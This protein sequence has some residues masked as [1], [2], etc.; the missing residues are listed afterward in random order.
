MTRCVNDYFSLPVLLLQGEADRIVS[1]IEAAR[2][3]QKLFVG[4]KQIIRSVPS[5]SSDSDVIS[6]CQVVQI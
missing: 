6:Q 2:E 5:H 3:W 1:P 4:G